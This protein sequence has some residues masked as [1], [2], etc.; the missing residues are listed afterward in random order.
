[1]WVTKKNSKGKSYSI[2]DKEF[3]KFIYWNFK[4]ISI[5]QVKCIQTGEYFFADIDI[6]RSGNR[7]LLI[8]NNRY[9]RDYFEHMEDKDMNEK[10]F[11][12]IKEIDKELTNKNKKSNKIEMLRATIK[13]SEK[14][15]DQIK[16]EDP[17]FDPGYRIDAGIARASAALQDYM[18]EDFDF[19]KL[20][21]DGYKLVED[22]KTNSRDA[23]FEKEDNEDDSIHIYAPEFV[24]IDP[25]ASD[26]Y[27]YIIV[28]EVLRGCEHYKTMVI[29]AKTWIAD[30]D[31]LGIKRNYEDMSKYI[32]T[33]AFKDREVESYK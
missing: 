29:D 7:Y 5:V 22:I 10:E 6:S 20:K 33:W 11:N 30:P 19:R 28:V 12:L 21:L 31:G 1:M 27:K 17:N 14:L 24:N 23:W 26:Y 3:D 16:K 15:L 32:L 9:Y 2:T 13:E 4:K 25:L 18:D 8:E